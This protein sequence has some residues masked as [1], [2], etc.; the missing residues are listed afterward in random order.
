MADYTLSAK[1][2]SDAN[3]FVKGFDQAIGKLNELS[4]K[5]KDVSKRVNEFGK[6]IG[7]IGG[8]LTNKI[9]KPAAAAATALV[10]L[11]L[12]KGFNRLAGIDE[13]RAKLMGLG[14]DA[15][16]VEKIM[17]SALESVKGTAFGMDEAA[18]TAASAVAA[19][20]K[21]GKELTRYLS[22]T[23]DAAAIAGSSMAEM[24]SI[25]N[26]VAT[27]GV[28]Q[29]E[30]L[31]QLADRGIPI[32][33]L[34][35][36]Q[37]GVTAQE[38]KKLASEGKVSTDIFLAAIEEGFGGAAKTMGEMSFM[39]NIRNIGAAISRIGANF[40]DAGGKA[41]GF[42]STVKP[43]LT[44]FRGYLAQI[45]EKAADWG[46]AFGNA[47]NRF[48]DGIR[49]LK[50]RFDELDPS[51]QSLILKAA[52]IGA[53]IA[54]G[55][56]PAL[57]FVGFLTAGFSGLI[58]ILSFLVSPIGV[59][60]A[61]IV[62]LGAVFAHLMATNEEF[63]AKVIEIFTNVRETI[64]GIIQ[65]IIPVVQ[66][67]WPTIKDTFA[68]IGSQIGQVL[69]TV[70]GIVQAILP[71]FKTF[72]VSIIEGFQ[73]VGIEG[74]SFGIQLSTILIGL[75]P[76]IKGII[77]L[78]QNFGPQIVAAFQQ[79]AQ[80]VIP[81]VANIGT[82]LGE[83]AATIIPVF[84]GALQTLIPVV[85]Q[86]GM[87]FMN[88]IQMVLPTLI[89]LITQLLPIISE[90]VVIIA[91]TAAQLMPLAA[92]LISSL[93]PVIVNI[94][95][96]VMNIVQ[97][98]APA[99][100]AIIN[101]I[102]Q[103]I[104]ALLPII[105]SIITVVVEVVSNVITTIGPIV[106]F[107]GGIINAVMAVIS[108][109]ITFIAGII[110][111]IIS[112]IRPIIDI[113]TGIFTTVFS[114]VSGIFR[115]IVTFIGGAINGISTIISGLSSIVSGVF[116]TIF[117]TVSRIMDRVSDKVTGVFDAIR[118]AWSGLTG[119]VGSIFDGISTS[120]Q[121]L[122]DQ[123]KGF[124]NKVIGGI[125]AAIKLIN[126]IPG[127]KI[128]KIPYLQHGTDNWAGGFAYMNE[129]GRGE[130]VHLPNGAQVIPH[131][132][133]MRYARE[134]GKQHAT[135]QEVVINNDSELVAKAVKSLEDT[136]SRLQLVMDDRVVAEIL[137]EP[138]TQ[139]QE[140][141]KSRVRLFRGEFA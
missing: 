133:S 12:V 26:K 121:K 15:Q 60:I 125:N 82:A 100:I 78:F 99:V 54:I 65:A 57:K 97:T 84:M 45:E 40:L 109:I 18:T 115:N 30:E 80:M 7:D 32:F 120:V 116:N 132:V 95:S 98:I 103:V 10:S 2:T 68:N 73:S 107:I 137:K 34:L 72:F 85:M 64:T 50:A 112:V 71:A 36:D 101:V 21:P 61:A 75:N 136:L 62:G 94:I 29:A 89:S 25:F 8:A 66:Q 52:G 9:T 16:S 87:A 105:M 83:I 3:S 117:S 124:V 24:G 33:Q 67:A 92:T 22:L 134:I 58:N 74:G 91:Q 69:Q 43:L 47:F 86:V 46:V 4:E 93:L 140:F 128:S 55:I 42:F 13:A 44:E 106:A 118:G 119:F 110:A 130:L 20:I 77:V 122:V 14:H 114:V 141:D 79:I 76:I 1:I 135:Q 41:G 38:V 113:V 59:V 88:I 102:T 63:R 126:K 131:D 123:V 129:G 138:I 104:Q 19:G 27:S 70:W 11:T 111:S 49:Q 48:I 39:A 31:N 28:A 56:G 108:P 96:T 37:M 90:I 5:T 35:A 127:V 139:L 53:A 6:K 51:V 23:A 17:E 81:L